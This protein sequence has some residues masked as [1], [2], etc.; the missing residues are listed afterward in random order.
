[1]FEWVGVSM[2]DV[3]VGIPGAA[4][5]SFRWDLKLRFYVYG[6]LHQAQ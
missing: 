1:M 4:A 3:H 6:S 2:G 5:M